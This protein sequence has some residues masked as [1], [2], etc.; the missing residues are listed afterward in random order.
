MGAFAADSLVK[1]YKEKGGN[2]VFV[3]LTLLDPFCL[4]GTLGF[5]YGANQY[6]LK[7]D[8]AQQY[9]NTVSDVYDF[10]SNSSKNIRPS[11]V[12]VP[13]T[14]FTYESGIYFR[15]I[16]SPRQIPLYQNVL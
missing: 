5:S 16:L 12:F 11:K 15:M 10:Y 3:Q 4:R 14:T 1:Q 6:G 2:D 7:A 13:N 8:Y 9:L